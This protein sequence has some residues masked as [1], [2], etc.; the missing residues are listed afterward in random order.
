MQRSLKLAV[1]LVAASSI[2][3][4]SG[5]ASY[6]QAKNFKSAIRLVGGD[7]YA[8]R[9]AIQRYG[10]KACHTIPGIPGA[11]GQVGPPLTQFGSRTYI[12]GELPNTPENLMR[13]IR[14]PHDVEPHTAMPEM[15]V[16]DKDSQ[17]IATYLYSLR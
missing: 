5:C 10:C 8:G 16:T 1:L 12:A 4:T 2:G 17:D 14:T 11:N 15:G 13:W 6:T 3:F 7:P 9:Q